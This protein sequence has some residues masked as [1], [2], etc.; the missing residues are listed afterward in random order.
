[1]WFLVHLSKLLTALLILLL[2]TIA[3]PESDQT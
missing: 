2:I 1:M 3:Y